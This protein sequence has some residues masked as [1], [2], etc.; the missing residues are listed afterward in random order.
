M[1]YFNV[2]STMSMRDAFL[3]A[4]G[5]SLCSIAASFFQTPFT[6][7]RQ[8]YGMRVRIACTSLVYNKVSQGTDYLRWCQEF[9]LF[10]SSFLFHHN[11]N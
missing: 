6:F 9:S 1:G 8:Q 2:D 3:Y 5:V 4:L 10:P 7:L 11:H